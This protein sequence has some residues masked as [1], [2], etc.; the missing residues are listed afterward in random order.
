MALFS[1]NH[2]P[3]VSAIFI[4]GYNRT[5]IGIDMSPGQISTLDKC[6]RDNCQP[7]ILVPK[8]KCCIQG[9]VTDLYPN[10]CDTISRLE[11]MGQ[12][13]SEY[14]HNPAL[15]SEIS[16]K[17]YTEMVALVRSTQGIL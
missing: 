15:R 9:C 11:E 1:G 8:G 5:K 6:R 16:H 4:F 12:S 13:W 2:P 17:Y 7:T 14:P 3:A 10:K